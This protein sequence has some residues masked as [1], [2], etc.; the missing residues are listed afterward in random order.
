M[1]NCL[2]IFIF[3]S[4]LN[5]SKFFGQDKAALVL[6]QDLFYLDIGEQVPG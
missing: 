4:N 1:S 3:L 2:K 5:N 6:N